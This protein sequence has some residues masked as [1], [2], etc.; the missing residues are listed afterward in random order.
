MLD[1]KRTGYDNLWLVVGHDWQA[2][3]LAHG[4]AGDAWQAEAKRLTDNFAKLDKKDVVEVAKWENEVLH[5]CGMHGKPLP[6]VK[7]PEKVVKAV[8]VEEVKAEPVK[9]AEAPKTE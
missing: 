1:V 4:F 6:A 5:A 3:M 8:A 7:Q 2:R 9:A